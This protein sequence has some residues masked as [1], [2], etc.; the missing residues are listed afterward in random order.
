[1]SNDQ[2]ASILTHRFSPLHFSD[3]PGFPNVVHIIDVWGDCLPWFRES[4]E[5]NYLDHLIRY[6]E[7]M[8]KLNIHH[9]YVCVFIRMGCS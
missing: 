4:K 6:H 2:M 3:V 8:D 9:E 1:M 5:D 7:C